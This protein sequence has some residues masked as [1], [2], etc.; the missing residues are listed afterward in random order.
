MQK[1]NNIMGKTEEV[2]MSK[3]K[4]IGIISGSVAGF[5][6]IAVLVYA[7][8][9]TS[10]GYWLL[11]KFKPD[12]EEQKLS[13]STA[14]ETIEKITDEGFVLMQNKDNFLPISTSEDNK[15]KINVFGT[16]S[17]VTLF[18]SGG[19]T[20]TD[21]TSAVKIEEALQGPDGNL[22]LNQ[23]L[24]NLHYNFYK[25]GNISIKETSAPKNKSDSE[26]LGE[27]SNLILPEVPKKAYEDTSL[28]NDEKT[29][30]EH[31]QEF[32]DTAMIVLGRGGGEMVNLSAFELQLSE[33]ESAMV[34]VVSSSFE[35]VILVI[36]GDG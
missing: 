24:L 33:E 2:K 29:I 31:A 32:S 8:V 4:K 1:G 23:D 17:I 5:I 18:N 16:R 14:I 36:L 25:K 35:N 15:K 11:A 19:S 28:Y 7:F 3:R 21:V 22:E 26:I 30:I 27:A 10:S 9:I 34:E 20:A 6:V 12:T 13:Y